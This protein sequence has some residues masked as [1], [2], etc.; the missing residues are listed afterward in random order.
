MKTK[1]LTR[2]DRKR[3]ILLA[4]AVEIQSDRT[5]E[6]TIANIARKLGLS[7]STHLRDMC[8]E[9]V[10][11]GSLDFR[12]ETIPGVAKFRRIYSPNFKKD[13]IYETIHLKRRAPLKVNSRQGTLLLGWSS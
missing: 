11:D 4:F 10:I 7:P 13:K 1:A 2:D 8:M 3:M 5:G 12:D 9:M 6:M